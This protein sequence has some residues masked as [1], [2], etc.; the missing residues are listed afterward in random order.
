MY[1]DFSRMSSSDIYFAMTQTIVPRPIAWVL[2]ENEDG[3]LNLAPFSYFAAVNSDPPLLSLSV[4]S[5]PDGALKDTRRNIQAR[6][7]FVVHIAH[8]EMLESLNASA[9]SLP[10]GASE[11]EMLGLETVAFEG[12]SLPRLKDCRVAFACELYSEVPLG[13]GSYALLLGK[14]KALYA[15]DSIASINEAGRLNVDAAAFQP[16]GR[17]GA[18]EYAYFGEVARL[19]PA[20]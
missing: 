12:F 14:I 7:Q 5:K 16:I 6:K 2:S 17:L 4:G 20:S 1:L 18:G 8:T 13:D 10:E 9:A 15:A 11:I 19:K 3:S